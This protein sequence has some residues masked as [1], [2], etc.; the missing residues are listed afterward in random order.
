MSGP[1]T[2]GG[3]P[4]AAHPGERNGG[5]VAVRTPT[6]RR[7]GDLERA[8]RSLLAQTW[9]RWTCEVR[10]DDPDAGGRAV[11]EALG[12]PRI[13]FRHNRPQLFAARNIDGCFSA[14][15]PEDADYFCVL[16]D[17]NFLLPR[18]M[19]DNIRVLRET[20]LSLLLRNQLVEHGSGTPAAR[21]G[22]EG[23][24]DGLFTERAYAPDE[25]RLALLMGIGMS[26]GG[27][28]WR[29]DSTSRLEI[30]PFQSTA[31]LQEYMRTFSVGEPVHVAMEPLAVWAQ[32]A[33]A[34][35]RNAGL[36]AS[37]LRREL[38]LKRR[39]Q[40][41]QRAAWAAAPREL[42]EGFLSDPRWAASPERR[43]R[44]MAKALIRPP[45]APR[46]GRGIAV[47]PRERIELA[48][49]GLLLRGAGRLTP[50]FDAFVRSR[51]GPSGRRPG[52]E[53]A[54]SLGHA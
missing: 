51:L 54:G 52:P 46:A 33:V 1:G 10:D 45:R 41:L 12:D 32:N 23:I 50:D 40:A 31:T 39:V 30:A 26:N 9:P 34:T 22:T 38:D 18:Y 49:R 4:P 19:E 44:G 17:D 20:G 21:V 42:R 13:R 27:I 8:L 53:A 29:R 37:W 25:M 2:N 28:F 15:N 43:L 36:R 3:G 14:E 5:L 47:G 16:E 48:A 24:L 11:V 6:Y 7:P 35:T